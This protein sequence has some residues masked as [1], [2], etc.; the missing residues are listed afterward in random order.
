MGALDINS[1]I[2]AT[3]ELCSTLRRE[4]KVE[5]LEGDNILATFIGYWLNNPLNAYDLTQKFVI[6]NDKI[7]S[8]EIPNQLR[9]FFDESFANRYQSEIFLPL[10]T[11]LLNLYLRMSNMAFDIVFDL[12]EEYR[13]IINSKPHSQELLNYLFNVDYENII[14]KIEEDSFTKNK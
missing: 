1:K 8:L 12:I 13:A 11:L 6:G 2:E 5:G 10:V 3:K 7:C 9:D 14:A 4:I